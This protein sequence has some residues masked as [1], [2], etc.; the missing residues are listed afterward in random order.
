[1]ARLF[2]FIRLVWG[3]RSRTPAGERGQMIIVFALL[4]PLVIFVVAAAAVDVGFWQ[5][6]RRGA[7]TAADLAALAAARELPGSDAAVIQY[8]LDYAKTNGYDD[9]DDDV[10]VLVTPR[11]KGDP[12]LV[13]VR[14][15]SQ[16]AGFFS[17]IFGLIAPNHGARA[18]AE[19]L[20]AEEQ[21]ALFA[22]ENSCGVDNALE[23]S[24]SNITVVGRSHTNAVLKVGGS[25]NDFEGAVTFVCNSPNRNQIHKSTDF[26]PPP[27]PTGQIQMPVEYELITTSS[28]T[29]DWRVRNVRTGAETSCTVKRNSEIILN[30]FVSGGVIPSGVYCTKDKLTL[31]QGN[32]TGNVTLVSLKEM[33]VGGSDI[34]LTPYWDNLLLFSYM[35]NDSA[36]DFSGQ[37]GRWE[38]LFYAPRGTAKIQGSD[39]SSGSL[40][41][42]GSII[43]DQ[44]RISGSNFTITAAFVSAEG[45]GLALVE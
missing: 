42:V 26:D 4:V 11:H 6:E 37:G 40:D 31:S 2:S 29:G 24:G 30:S 7:Q 9:A 27:A 17:S 39:G 43:A 35:N 5:S 36:L 44:I 34:S 28:Q 1:M 12:D 23:L 20:T 3:G 15:D 33:T 38:G 45:S 25:D 8:G 22:N 10:S 14:I 32:V 19:Y 21:Y 18:V 41:I 13:E 16:S